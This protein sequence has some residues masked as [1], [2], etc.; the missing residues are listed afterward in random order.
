[1]NKKIATNIFLGIT[2]IIL[3]YCIFAVI[4]ARRT[5]EEV[6][7]FGHKPYIIQTGS[8]EP[9]LR[10]NSLIIVRQGG[11][12]RVREGDKISFRAP[13]FDVNVCH[14]VLYIEDERIH[15]KRR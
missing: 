10:V 11:F 15:Y 2:T 4:Q 9:A 8:M 7:I 5:G 6:F 14:R 3:I 12:E 1:M 13:G